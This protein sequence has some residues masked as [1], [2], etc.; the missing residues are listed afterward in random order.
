MEKGLSKLE[1]HNKN[2]ILFL[3][4][5][6]LRSSSRER[7]ARREIL[8]VSAHVSFNWLGLERVQ[9]SKLVN[10]ELTQSRLNTWAKTER[11]DHEMMRISSL[12]DFTGQE[13]LFA[14]EVSV[15]NKA[16]IW[17]IFRGGGWSCSMPVL[18][19]VWGQSDVEERS[20]GQD[21][22]TLSP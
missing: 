17:I 4:T 18:S 15:S 8:N 19:P 10:D 22:V 6:I 14:N 7:G 3:L 11:H 21:R 1:R 5:N 2:A 20:R 13:L 9:S 16:I 12:R